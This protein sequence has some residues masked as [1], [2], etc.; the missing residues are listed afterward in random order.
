MS[1]CLP[2]RQRREIEYHQ[3]HAQ[4]DISVVV[5]ARNDAWPLPSV[6]QAIGE[7]IAENSVLSVY[8]NGSEDDTLGIAKKFA[9]NSSFPVRVWN[10]EFGDKSNAWNWYIH[11]SGLEAK[12]HVFI[13]GYSVIAKGSLQALL[14]G[15]AQA[16]GAT[17]VPSFGPSAAKTRAVMLQ[18]GGFHGSYHVLAG[19][20][21]ERLRSLRIFLPVG[22]YIQDSFI[23]SMLM[24]DL[25]ALN[26][27]WTDG[28]IAVVEAATWKTMKSVWRD[29][30]RYM[31]RKIN[32]ARGKIEI[33][34]FKE[35]IYK[36]GF[37]ALPPNADLMLRDYIDSH[38]IKP[39]LFD[40]PMRA[41]LRALQNPRVITERIVPKMVLPD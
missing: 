27:A 16:K 34:A 12:A 32:K 41:A 2:D 22:T 6:L 39:T 18:H 25:D 20:F 21:V 19:G 13:D 26:G 24:H 11:H 15:L 35:I 33:A 29:P 36:K 31:Q 10:I 40:L 3:R 17:A 28:N 1:D 23:G 14:D 8:V 38:P 37:G 9:A 4:L 7:Q 30:G 5:I